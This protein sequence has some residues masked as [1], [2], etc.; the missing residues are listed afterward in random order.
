MTKKSSLTLVRSSDDVTRP[1]PRKLGKH[2]MALWR[3]IQSNY[4]IVDAGGVETLAQICE[5][6]ERAEACRRQIERDGELV[7]SRSG[8]FREH[9]LLK[10][11]LASRSFVVRGLQRL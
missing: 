10:I 11:E 3:R 9:P 2:G 7:K 6:A 1:P 8:V 4:E 5:Q